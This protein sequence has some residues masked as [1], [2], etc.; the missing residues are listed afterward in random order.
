M[1]QRPALRSRVQDQVVS[2][3]DVVLAVRSTHWSTQVGGRQAFVGE[4]EG[5]HSQPARNRREGEKSSTRLRRPTTAD[6]PE[7]VG[8]QRSEHVLSRQTKEVRFSHETL[9]RTFEHGRHLR[10]SRSPSHALPRSSPSL[11]QIDHI[12]VNRRPGE[13]LKIIDGVILQREYVLSNVLFG[14]F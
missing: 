11:L 3:S 6:R 5:P 4:R 14:S 1:H 2:E 8:N 13:L 9:R 7:E 12:Q 10:G